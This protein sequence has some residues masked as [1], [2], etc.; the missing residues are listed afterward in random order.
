MKFKTPDVEEEFRGLRKTVKFQ[1][2]SRL[3]LIARALDYYCQFFFKKEITITHVLRTQEQ[4]DSFYR[5][6]PVYKVKSWKSVH[7]FGRGVDIRSMDFEEH[8]IKQIVDWVNMSFPYGDGKHATCICH[9][10]GQGEHIHLQI[11]Y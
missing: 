7:Q 6:D 11:I 5:D 9:N 3:G 2:R 10:V 1:F 8:E 4:Q